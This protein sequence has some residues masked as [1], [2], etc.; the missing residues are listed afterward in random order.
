MIKHCQDSKETLTT[1]QT[2]SGANAIEFQNG[3]GGARGMIMG[4]LKKEVDN[5]FNIFITA[6]QPGLPKETNIKDLQGDQKDSVKGSDSKSNIGFYV[7]CQMGL[8][9]T[10]KN[11]INLIH[12]YRNFKNSF[13]IAYDLNKSQIGLNPLRC[14]RLSTAAI[15]AFN[16]NDLLAITD[17]LVQEKI[18]SNKLGI[19]TMF[20][21]VTLKIHRS[22]L[23]QAFLFD[24]IQPHIPAFNTNVLKMSSNN[25]HMAQH[26]YQATEK[27][28]SL[29]DEM[30]R[31]EAQHKS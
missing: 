19:D 27:S 1:G 28:A 15:D 23:L 14:Y 10:H 21:E 7:S 24:H 17:E 9:F 13:M 20:E 6:T 30:N 2:L 5:R 4:V 3:L 11:L 18:N 29:I 22:H 26:L 31:I 16:L 8:A 25:Q 12:Q